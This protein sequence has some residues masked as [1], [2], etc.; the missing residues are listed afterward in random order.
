MENGFQRWGNM[1]TQ[2]VIQLIG[3]EKWMIAMI[4]TP[5]IVHKLMDYLTSNL[6]SYQ[7]WLQD[8]GLLTMNNGN[9]YAGAG[10]R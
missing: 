3:M 7:Q 1:I 4:E 9:H 8:E 2:K 10:S 5:E 6:I